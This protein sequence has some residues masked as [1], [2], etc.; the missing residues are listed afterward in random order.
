[1][2]ARREGD[3]YVVEITAD[4]AHVLIWGGSSDVVKHVKR[5]FLVALVGVEDNAFTD[6][7]YRERFDDL[8]AVYDRLRK[9]V[10]A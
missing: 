6:D 8:D 7:E 4:E 3:G 9:D 2:N 1:M 5:A 10:S